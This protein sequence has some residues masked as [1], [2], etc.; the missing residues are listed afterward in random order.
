[1]LISGKEHQA[2]K[3][4][5]IAI[6]NLTVLNSLVI[7]QWLLAFTRDCPNTRMGMKRNQPPGNDE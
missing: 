4:K 3:C 2:L 5:T 6:P 7:S 1:M